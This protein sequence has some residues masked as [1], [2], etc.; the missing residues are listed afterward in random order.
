MIAPNDSSHDLPSPSIESNDTWDLRSIFSGNE[1]WDRESSA[2]A[3]AL[4]HIGSYEGRLLESA[5]TLH[6]CLV[7]VDLLLERTGRVHAYAYLHYYGDTTN[8]TARALLDRAEQLS[9]DLDAVSGFLEPELLA[10]DPTQLRSVCEGY[11]ALKEYTFYF[12]ELERARAHTLSAAEEKLI[13][14]LSP[15]L[16]QPEGFRTALNDTDL[17]FAPV[18][19]GGERVEVTHGTVD[20]LLGN[21]DRS[22]RRAVYESYTGGYLEFPASFT[23]A[24]TGQAKASLAFA[25]VRN[26]ESTLHEAIFGEAIPENTFSSVLKICQEQRPLFQRYFR[27]RAK[28]LGLE[29]IAEYDLLAPLSTN[30]PQIPYEKAIDLVLASLAPLGNKYLEVATRGLTVER[31][32]DV[33]PKEG[34]YSNAFSGGAYG[35]RPF[36]LLNYAPTMQ[37]VG[38]LAHELGHSMHTFIANAQQPFRYASYS[39]IVAETAS[40]LNQVLLRAHVLQNADRDTALAVLD[41]AFFFAHRYLFLMPTLSEVEHKLHSTYAEGGA[42]SATELSAE[43]VKAFSAAYGDAVDFDPDRLG[44]KWAHFCH[45]YMPYYLIQYAIGI[46]ASM[47]IGQRILDGEPGITDKYLAFLGAGGSM[48]TADIFK[49]VDI[50]ITAPETYRGAFN[51]VEGYVGLLEKYGA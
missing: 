43:T 19:V 31:W 46:S 12:S 36:L 42:M 15:L 6:K 32:A 45:F 10:A 24:I 51:V 1:S 28:I 11:A 34:K 22:V 35:T 39:S 49:I 20:S 27:A 14:A 47:A 50:D 3:T 25:K 30:P 16:S 38:T 41:E 44:T 21:R 26:F 7:E 18:T 9:A 48:H 23:Q 40:N 4:A 5:E 2:I 33:Y 8:E 37:E 17:K 13:G 29:K